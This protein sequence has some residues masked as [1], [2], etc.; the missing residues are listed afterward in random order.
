ML[1]NSKAGVLGKAWM[2]KH[3]LGLGDD[4]G[5]TSRRR[6]TGD[7]AHP[8]GQRDS[9][10]PRAQGFAAAGLVDPQPQRRNGGG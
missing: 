2:D 3:G 9:C 7:D 1:N 10:L 5:L 8:Y 4:Y 6:G